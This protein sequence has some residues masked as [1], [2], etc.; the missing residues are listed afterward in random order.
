MRGPQLP[1][2]TPCCG[3]DTETGV[4]QPTIRSDVIRCVICKKSLQSR[5]PTPLRF[6]GRTRLCQV[7]GARAFIRGV[8]ATGSLSRWHRHTSSTTRAGRA[9]AHRRA[10][11]LRFGAGVARFSL[12]DPRSLA[13]ERSHPEPRATAGGSRNRPASGSPHMGVPT[14]SA[15]TSPPRWCCPLAPESSIRLRAARIPRA[16]DRRRR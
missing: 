2:T 7:E 6:P 1:T 5:S 13:Y 4:L 8:V 14:D 12:R 16:T 15:P 9:W 11:V 10:A 3:R